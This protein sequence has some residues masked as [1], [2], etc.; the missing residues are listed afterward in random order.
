MC[1]YIAT[2]ECKFTYEST[3]V[4]VLLT[5]IET[6]VHGQRL[7]S[8][9]NQCN[10]LC[11]PG[12]SNDVEITASCLACT[13]VDTY[14]GGKKPESLNAG[15]RETVVYENA[16]GKRGST[17][18][19]LHADFYEFINA[20][21]KMRNVQ[22]QNTKIT[23]TIE[24]EG[25]KDLDR[26]KIPIKQI[27]Q[28]SKKPKTS[29]STT[30]YFGTSSFHVVS[31]YFL[32]INNNFT[33]NMNINNGNDRENSTDVKS[34][35]SASHIAAFSAKRHTWLAE[36]R[37]ERKKKF[38]RWKGN[39]VFISIQRQTRKWPRD[40]TEKEPGGKMNTNGNVGSQEGGNGTDYGS[41]EETAALLSRA[42]PPPVVVAA[43]SQGKPVL[44]RQDRATFLVASPQLSVSGLG[45][46]EES[47]T[48]EDPATRSVPD[49]ELH[50]RLDGEAQPQPQLPQPQPQTQVQQTIVPTG[51]RTRQSSH[52]HRCRCDR[53]D[54]LAPSSALHLARSVSSCNPI[55]FEKSE[56]HIRKCSTKLCL[57]IKRRASSRSFAETWTVMSRRDLHGLC[58]CLLEQQFPGRHISEDGP[59]N[60]LLHCQERRENWLVFSLHWAISNQAETWR[61]RW[62]QLRRIVSSSEKREFEGEEYDNLNLIEGTLQGKSKLARIVIT[63]N[64]KFATYANTWFYESRRHIFSNFEKEIDGLWTLGETGYSH[65]QP[66]HIKRHGYH[67]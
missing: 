21:F 29:L 13:R 24:F 46:S 39:V 67:S 61:S 47:G 12:I 27:P 66:C 20:K 4:R 62:K 36:K 35:T 60:P 30:Q 43:A 2:G 7:E 55:L 58:T 50:C 18:E 17:F 10:C 64:P 22:V 3:G 9:K 25:T 16:S 40:A 8:P 52:Q 38:A 15:K 65:F 31:K 63:K 23:N 19:Q 26:I 51:Y 5:R 14:R 56:T 37:K 28:N 45:G 33:I 32:A 6:S 44:T 1:A 11:N 41:S 34:T 42:P 53:R 48:T 59:T 49:I 57:Q 54:S